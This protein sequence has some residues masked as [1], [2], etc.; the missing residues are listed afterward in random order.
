MINAPKTYVIKDETIKI[1]D[2]YEAVLAV[3]IFIYD[4]ENQN[5]FLNGLLS[6]YYFGT[7]KD[8]NI[9]NGTTQL[10][11]YGETGNIALSI[12]AHTERIYSDTLMFLCGSFFLIF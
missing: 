12:H 4:Y 8:A 3:A 10:T 5:N 1:E 11:M 7:E 9:G 6:H 2:G